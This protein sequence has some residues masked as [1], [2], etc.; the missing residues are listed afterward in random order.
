M[1]LYDERFLKSL[2]QKNI[3]SKIY[4]RIFH[5]SKGGL[6]DVEKKK[7]VDTTVENIAVLRKQLLAAEKEIQTI[8]EQLKPVEDHLVVVRTYLEKI[9][10]AAENIKNSEIFKG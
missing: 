3:S 10:E 6:M 8:Y 4:N 7:I 5:L 9:S 1:T 2:K